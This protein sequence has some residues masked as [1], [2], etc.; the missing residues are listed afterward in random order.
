MVAIGGG[1]TAGR[2]IRLFVSANAGASTPSAAVIEYEFTVES[3]AN[4]TAA[5]LARADHEELSNGVVD[6]AHDYHLL[7]EDRTAGRAR[8]TVAFG[9]YVLYF[10]TPRTVDRD[11]TG[12]ESSTVID[13]EYSVTYRG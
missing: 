8:G 9:E 11:E 10:W 5:V 4:V 2:G 13:F 1:R 3:G 6:P 12:T 7:V